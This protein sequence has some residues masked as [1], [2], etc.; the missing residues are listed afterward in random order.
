MSRGGFRRGGFVVLAAMALGC[1][2]EEEKPLLLF[3][4]VLPSR[5]L[6]VV[7]EGEIAAGEERAFGLLLPR[8]M[9]VQAKLDDA[10][11]MKGNLRFDDVTNFVRRRVAAAREET[12]PTKTVFVDAAVL[13]DAEERRVQVEISKRDAKIWMVVRDR[14]PKPKEEGLSE[15]ERW[16]RAGIGRGGKVLREHAQ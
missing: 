7:E 5:P 4:G 10:W 15:A 11:H 13:G 8:E 9:R 12:G 3:P 2:P 6:D 16:R 1:A 14:T